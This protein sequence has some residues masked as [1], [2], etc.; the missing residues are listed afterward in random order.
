[1][2]YY[3]YI[4]DIYLRVFV[5]YIIYWLCII[6]PRKIDKLYFKINKIVFKNG[7]RF[8][9][10]RS[11]SG[12]FKTLLY[13]F[14][15]KYKLSIEYCWKQLQQIKN[16]HYFLCACTVFS[17]QHETTALTHLVI[18]WY[19]KITIVWCTVSSVF[20]GPLLGVKLDLVINKKT[21]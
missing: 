13:L 20:H 17:S 4:E 1:M 2:F 12:L 7:K 8:R 16:V 5:Y 15:L 3:N 21:I 18:E 19:Q 11:S 14:I 10:N 6:M 9:S